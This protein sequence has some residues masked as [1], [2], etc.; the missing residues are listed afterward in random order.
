MHAGC[1]VVLEQK[2]TCNDDN[3][4]CACFNTGPTK[5]FV[6]CGWGL[7]AACESTPGCAWWQKPNGDV[8][9]ACGATPLP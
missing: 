9:C 1:R 5:E 8:Y 3:T 4:L 6:I 7:V 2:P